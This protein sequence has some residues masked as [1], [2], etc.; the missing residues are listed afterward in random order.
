MRIEDWRWGA[1]GLFLWV[2]TAQPVMAQAP[3]PM[4]DWQLSAG[5]PLIAHFV[6]E[7]PHWQGAVGAGLVQLPAYEGSTRMRLL[8]VAAAE[9]RYR[10]VAYFSSSEGLGYNFFRGKNYRLGSS[11]GYDIGREER[12]SPKLAGQ[13]NLDSAP[14][15]KFYAERVWFPVV[16]RASVRHALDGST[17]WSSDLGAYL[18]VAGSSR[19]FV[20]AGSAVSFADGSSNQRRFGVSAAQGQG[21]SLPPHQAGGGLRSA[22]LGFSATYFW[23]DQWFANATGSVQQ[24]LGAAADSPI[25]EAET[26][27]ALLMVAGYRW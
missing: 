27:T 22:S 20:L 5:V 25:V 14:E 9:F 8:P 6:K 13:G 12:R 17:G 15:L 10:D 18:P 24:L 23:D 4:A 11:L 21:G 2:L 3:T 1:A 26:Q 16:L 19:Y 7:V